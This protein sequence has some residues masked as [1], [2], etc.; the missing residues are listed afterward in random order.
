MS[1]ANVLE[2]QRN[3]IKLAQNMQDQQLHPQ[4]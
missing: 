4:F 3:V 2:T 1:Q